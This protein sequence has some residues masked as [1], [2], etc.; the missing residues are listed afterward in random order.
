MVKKTIDV[1]AK[2]SLQI[3]S[4]TREINYKYL[5]G[6]RPSVKKDKSKATWEYQNR[7]KDKTKS[8]NP[9]FCLYKS[10]FD[11]NFQER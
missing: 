9:F 6:Y 8:H 2:T 1:E 4:G 5:K 7:D 3:L 11:S 10:A